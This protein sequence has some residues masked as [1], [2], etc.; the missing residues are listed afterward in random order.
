MASLTGQLNTEERGKS[1]I[2]GDA[3]TGGNLL[4]GLTRVAT[5]AI[6]AAP[7]LIQRMEQRE[8]RDAAN[9]AEQSMFDYLSAREEALTGPGGQ[10]DPAF[11]AAGNELAKAQAA[12]NQGRAPL[13]SYEVRAEKVVSDLY[14]R[15]PNQRAAIAQYLQGRGFDHYMFQ[16]VKQEEK[17]ETLEQDQQRAAYETYATAA[18]NAG[19][20]DPNNQEASLAAGRQIL[21]EQANLEVAI[22]KI[23]L[24]QT[25]ATIDRENARFQMEQ[26]E[27]EAVASA[28]G[29]AWLKAGAILPTLNSL[30]ANAVG[31]K[32]R[33]QELNRLKPQITM[34]IETFRANGMAELS[35]AGASKE[36]RDAFNAQMDQLAESINSVY[37]ESFAVNSRSLNMM[38]ET[39]AL[40]DANALPLYGRLVRTFGQPAVNAWFGGNP[41]DTLP[42]D[43]L[44]GLQDELKG[45]NTQNAAKAAVTMNNVAQMLKG[46]KGLGDMSEAE[47]RD[48]F[49][50][51]RSATVGLQ[52][53]VAGGDLSSGTSYINGYSLSLNAAS[54][55]QPGTPDAKAVSNAINTIATVG[56]S[57]ALEQLAK[58]DAYDVDS[59]VYAARGTAGQLLRVRQ[60]QGPDKAG[61]WSLVFDTKTGDYRLKQDVKAAQR[62]KEQQRMNQVSLFGADT[63][64][65][66]AATSPQ[67]DPDKIP[68]VLLQ[69]QK[70]LNQALSFLVY[71]RQFDKE[72]VTGFTP[73]Q[74]RHHYALGT[75]LTKPGGA[76]KSG[77]GTTT[78]Q[79]EWQSSVAKFQQELQNFAVTGGEGPSLGRQAPSFKGASISPGNAVSRLTGR[80]VPGH[81]ANGIVGNL[82]AE[83]GL[84]TGAVG[85][86]GKAISL[87]Q[88]HPDRQAHARQKGYNLADPNDALDF[89]LEELNTTEAEA[90]RKL[91]SARTAKE[92]ADIFALYF[93]RPKGAETGSADNVHN[94]AG[95][96]RFAMELSGE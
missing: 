66:G 75:P 94:I 52:T 69:K 16:A 80:G 17:W 96:R 51:V 68:D 1:T 74:F 82:M 44:K 26:G 87:A 56:A 21:Q 91:M 39:F 31:D 55:L 64:I 40:D 3:P 22:K 27:K 61:T 89:V 9:Q 63:V 93:L 43:V 47:A 88:W 84:R 5:Q 41:L 20:W 48:H 6:G 86:G 78:A 49:K 73:L 18:R 28:S 81:I 42:P 2:Q 60:G 67:G 8:A 65:P 23:Q 4:S 38:K 11:K 71:T 15:F 50:M 7:G 24:A 13:G 30:M 77:G 14:S 59:L 34:A 46:Q 32:A 53:A 19:V 36:A 90:K 37:N 58:S 29:I 33:E 85:D 92:A 72:E 83:S 76:S 25:Q 62:I 57:R 79:Q 70:D 10:V 35:R 12:E 45:F 54:E 95:R